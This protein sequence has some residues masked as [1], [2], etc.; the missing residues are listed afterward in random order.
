MGKQ[1]ANIDALQKVAAIRI[2]RKRLD[3]LNPAEYN[4]R[5]R[6]QPGDEEYEKLKRS[7][8][9]FTYVDPIII[10]ADGTVIGGHQRLFVLRDLGYTE[11]D[12]SVVDLS[13]ADEKA[14]NIALNKIGGEWD[15]EKL[16]AL[17]ADLNAED[18]DLTLTGFAEEE[19]NGII[20]A[21]T[22]GLQAEEKSD[23]DEVPEVNEHKEPVTKPGDLWQ[24][25]RHRLMCGDSTSHDMFNML[26]DG[27]TA[28]LCVTSPPYGV[29]ME[30]EEK[31]IDPWRKTISGVI[32]TITKFC[33]IIC[34]NIGD[35]FGTGTQFIEPTSMYST[36]YMK[37]N[38]FGIMY[39]RIWKKQGANFNGVNPYHLVSMKPV[40]EYEWIL[41]Y[42][43][44]D[45]ENDYGPIIEYM[46]SEFD[47]S[48]ITKEQ[49]AEI[50]GAKHMFGHWF[51]QHQWTMIDEGNWRKIQR[52][53]K[54]NAI[55]AFCDEYESIR[56]KYDD[57]SIFQKTLTDDERRS[58]GQWAVWEIPT[59]SARDGHP[60]AFPI[61]LPSRLI[62]LHSRVGDNVIEPFCG[63]GTT[64]IACEQ[65]ERTCF[66]MERDPKYCDVIVKRYAAVTGKRDIVLLRDGEEIPAEDTGILN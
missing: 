22:E 56:R 54:D 20:S 35:L 25:G 9:T 65:L 2:D 16:S 57:L 41:G 38:G 6:L 55:N 39:S 21:L 31:G 46:K 32:S 43:K 40:Q 5:K 59:V 23:P 64:L 10:N 66:G 14:L 27:N 15:D 62:K 44:I 45:Y 33:R 13:K 50:T 49:L 7:I 48:G 12:V 18:Y 8:D 29:G 30:Y 52:Y 42:A 17:F 61:E 47:K 3:D 60:A 28:R 53:C 37:Q 24:I 58:W 4:P 36:D 26:M 11:A 34:W 19:Y 1:T 63:S 51:T